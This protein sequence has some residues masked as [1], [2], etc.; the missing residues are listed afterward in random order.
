MPYLLDA[1]VF[2]QAKNQHYGFDFCP[3]FW[4]WLL[5]ANTAQLVFSVDEIGAELK[6]GSDALATWATAR[7][8][9]FFLKPDSK[10]V[11]SLVTTSNWAANS[12]FGPAAVSGFLAVA[13]YHLVARAHAEGYIV[14]TH[15]ALDNSTKRIKIPV[16]CNGLGVVW[17]T[18]F[19]MLSIENARFVVGP[20]S[21]P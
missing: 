10:V 2:I 21:K 9:K 17:K 14:V 15:E 13:D 16:A 7:D 3:A 6:A 18:P 20:G 5:G 12:G 11:S 8:D 19:Q 4:D 1:N